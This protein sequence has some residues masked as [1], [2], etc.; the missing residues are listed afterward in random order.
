MHMD[1][2]NLEDVIEEQGKKAITDF[3]QRAPDRNPA[4]AQHH[5]IAA[6]RPQRRKNPHQGGYR[7]VQWR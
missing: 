1:V 4:P 3:P 7:C 5:G 6:P 2:G